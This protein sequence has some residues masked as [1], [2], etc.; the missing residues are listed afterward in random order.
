MLAEKVGAV[1]QLDS[2]AFFEALELLVAQ[3]IRHALQEMLQGKD[4]SVRGAE[5]SSFASSAPQGT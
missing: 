2:L 5:V 3:I 4:G 1:W